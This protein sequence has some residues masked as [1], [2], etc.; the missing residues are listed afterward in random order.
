V[1]E[2]HY[3]K[4]R[5]AESIQFISE[6]MKEFDKEYAS[7]TWEDYQND[8]KIQKLVDKTVENILTAVIEVCGTILTE[9][10]IAV[11]SYPDTLKKIGRFFKFSEKEQE[12]LAKLAIQ[13]NRLVH[14]YLNFRW[15]AVKM[16]SGQRKLVKKLMTLILEREKKKDL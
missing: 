13:R 3:A 12:N 7:K 6:E 10:K 1:P 9:E 15:Q 8:K 14:R 2:Y 16:F 11:D 4:G 5:I